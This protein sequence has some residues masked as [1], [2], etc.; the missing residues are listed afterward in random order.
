MSNQWMRCNLASVLFPF[1]T[2]LW[3]RSIVIPQYDQNYDRTTL[4]A[5]GVIIDKGIPQVFY[6]HNC[7]P[8]SQGYQSIGY[9]PLIPPFPGGAATDF[10]TCYQIYSEAGNKALFVPAAGKNYI[11]DATVG[12][13][14]SISPFAAGTVP[15]NVQV[16]TA[17]INGRTYIFYAK[18]GCFT[19]DDSSK[20]L[21]SI[22]LIG[23]TIADVL[24]VCAANGYMITWTEAEIAWSSLVDPTDFTPSLTTGAGGGGVNEAKGTITACLAIS[25]GFLAYCQ[26]N[27]VSAQYSGNVQFPYIFKE[28]P[29]SGGISSTRQVSWHSNLNNQMAWTGDGLQQMGLGTTTEVF[30]E[31]NDFLAAKLFEDFDEVSLTFSLQ[32]LPAALRTN[33]TIIEARYVVLSYGISAPDFTHAL[34]YDLRLNRWG[35]M[36]VTHR[37]C[38]EYNFPNLYGSS[39]TYDQLTQT[40]DQFGSTTYDEFATSTSSQDVYKQAFCFLQGDGT[41]KVVDFSFSEVNADGVMVC[42]KFQFQRNSRIEHQECAVD[43]V[44]KANNFNYYV[45]PSWDGKTLRTPVPGYLAIEGDQTRTYKK[46]VEGMNISAMFIGS[47]HMVSFELNFTQGGAA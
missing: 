23:L 37:D 44:D 13:W 47:F 2:E 46:V 5:P 26:D 18:Y 7:M 6:M 1:A 30:P 20:T 17:F 45:V 9:L 4:N 42:G 40:Y 25:G 38:F 22:T 34:I 11:Y 10:D 28:I 29:G 32:Y 35:K 39:L 8:T 27:T 41:V 19:Y 21:T 36:K 43:T 33:I 12:T 31:A 16:T 15:A 24:G 3:G 14:T